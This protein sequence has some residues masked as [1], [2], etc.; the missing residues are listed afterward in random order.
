[1]SELF[2]ILLKL[3]ILLIIIAWIL[4]WLQTVINKQNKPNEKP[5]SFYVVTHDFN[6]FRKVISDVAKKY[7]LKTINEISLWCKL[8]EIEK[9]ALYN[10]IRG[11]ESEDYDFVH[12]RYYDYHS[13]M[14]KCIE[15]CDIDLWYNKY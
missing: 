11:M 14:K 7:N 15:H 4:T 12:D 5:S 10:I 1:M 2:F 3:F 13:T 8:D 9:Y 6:A